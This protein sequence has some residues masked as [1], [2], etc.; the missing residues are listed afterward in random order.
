MMKS[1]H[2]AAAILT[3]SLLAPAGPSWSA[4]SAARTDIRKGYNLA[5]VDANIRRVADAILGAMLGVDYS[6]DPDVSGNITLRTSAPVTREQLIPLLEGALQSVDAVII[7]EGGRY[8]V[9][10]RASARTKAPVARSGADTSSVAGYGSEILTLKYASAGEM[11]KLLEQ[12]LGKE[13]VGGSNDALNQVIIIG[14]TA[15]RQA[16]RDLI[17]RFDVDM[18]ANMNFEIYKL[19]NTDAGSL[20]S[21]LQRI[22]K[23]PYDIIGSRVRLV[24][25]PR[26]HSLIV[27]AADRADF[28]RIEPW[29]RRLDAGISGKRKLYTYRVQ[30]GRARDLATALQQ[31]LGTS[32]S[33]NPAANSPGGDAAPA[34]NAA[35]ATSAGMSGGSAGGAATSGDAKKSN[36]P[37]M[38]QETAESSYTSSSGVRVVPNEQTN[39]L[40]IFADGEEYDLVREV[41]QS[42]D[43]PVP[44]VLIEA[45]LA[46]V[47]LNNDFQF[48]VDFST[49]TGKTSIASIGN[50]SG[51]PAS[52]FPGLSVAYVGGTTR[53]ILSTLQSKTNVRVLSAPKLIVLNNQTATLQVGDQVPI[54][55]QQSQSVS[56]PGAPIVNNVELKDTGVILNVTPRV[57]DGGTVTLDITQEVS[58][59]AETTTSGI[60]SPTIQQRRIAT[61]VSTRTGMMVALGGLIRER[62]SNTR[63][64]IPLLSQIPVLGGVFG[65]TSR[66]GSRTELIILL[67]PTVIRA[68]EDVKGIVDQLINGLDAARP[69]VDRARRRQVG[70]RLPPA[71]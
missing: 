52:T 3:L 33:Q 38:A 19:D 42:I 11:A 67:T 5:F 71:Q 62:V 47:T 32:T 20:V 69:L 51:V 26:L 53:A 2:R 31:V 18:L 9:V 57:N 46:E 4:P 61:T 45:T 55:T 56:A 29:I 39:S 66:G 25:L 64:G 40:L 27:I 48:G 36:T 13:I 24:P 37:V 8:R 44:Q 65:R 41:L 49:L 28:A 30:N 70:D 58:D 54:V 15:E 22:F 21:E 59:V 34:G 12:F 43:Q 50:G 1:T 63:S 23:G 17:A 14:G 68:P 60:N 35:A 6:V 7:Q 16:A 10:A